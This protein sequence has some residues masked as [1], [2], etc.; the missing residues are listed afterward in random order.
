M[1]RLFVKYRVVLKTAARLL[2][3]FRESVDEEFEVTE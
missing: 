1:I 2:Y 3:D